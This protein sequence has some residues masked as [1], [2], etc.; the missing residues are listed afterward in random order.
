MKHFCQFCAPLSCQLSCHSP[1]CL[2]CQCQNPFSAACSATC[3][4]TLFDIFSQFRA[5]K[6]VL[7]LDLFRAD[8]DGNPDKI[9]ENQKKRFK[10][11]RLVDTVVE[12]DTLWRQLRHDADNYNKLKNV[13]SKEIGQKMKSKEP[14]GPENEPVPQEVADKLVDLTA[15]QLRPLTVNQIKKVRESLK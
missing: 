13:C 14:V 9:R 3:T 11:V 1:I 15:E 10:D 7:D 5:S 8:K 4:V 12:Q 2:L 6:M